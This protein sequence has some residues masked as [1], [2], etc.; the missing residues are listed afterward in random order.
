MRV[1]HVLTSLLLVSTIAAPGLAQSGS[2]SLKITSYPTGA[3]VSI[4]GID[5]GKTTPMSESLTVG[6]HTVLVRVPNSGW[7]PDTRLV[8]IVSGNNDLSVTLLPALTMGPQGAAGPVGPQGVTGPVGPAGET[9]P[10]GSTGPH[11]PTGPQ[12]PAG[13]AGTVDLPALDLRYARVT[14]GNA[15]SGNQNVAG[16]ITLT[17]NLD[18]LTGAFDGGVA[19][20]GGPTKP[21][22]NGVRGETSSGVAAGVA[23][24]NIAANGVG[25]RGNGAIGVEGLGTGAGSRGLRGHGAIGVEGF[26]SIWGITGSTNTAGARGVRG[27]YDGPGLGY[28][29][30]A[31]TAASSGIALQAWSIHGTGNTIG[32]RGMVS[33]P[34]GIGG[35]FDNSAGGIVIQG[36]ANGALRFKVD[37]AGAVYAN[38]YRDLAGN[39]IPTGSGDVTGITVGLGITGGGTSGDVAVGL[40]TGYTDARYALMHHGHNVSQVVGAATLE[41]NMFSGDQIVNGTVRATTSVNGDG[42]VYGRSVGA[43]GFGVIGDTSATIGAAAGVY[44]LARAANGAGSVHGVYGETLGLVGSA[45]RGL[46][47]HQY[48]IGTEGFALGANGTAM[49]AQATASTGETTALLAH[50][51]S[52]TGIVAK[53]HSSGGDFIVGH[54]LSEGDKFRVDGAGNVF[55]NT[56]NI[57][58][59]DFAESVAVTESKDVYGAGDAMI[60]DSGLRRTMTRSASPYSTMVAGIYSTNPGVIASP[61]GIGDPRLAAEIP[62]AVVG[63]VPCKVSAENGPISPG[64]LLVTSSLA[65]HAMKGTDRARMLGAILGKALEPHDRGTGTILVLVTLQ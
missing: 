16:N 60:I 34:N 57:G 51:A 27:S 14:G 33:S 55:A 50:V 44:G 5:T 59:A 22:A 35:V 49:L 48:G 3:A 47:R 18:A 62:L 45:V 64:D 32:V 46:A 12:G 40:D 37:S 36:N 65:G 21:N 28:G 9:G 4:D 17:G 15:F 7:N 42:A 38:S 30:E 19:G 58:G 13:P 43:I 11:G 10:Q 61:Y 26:G 39:P 8:T 56:F 63:I 25:V 20:F 6:E 53:L 23:G 54:R 2:G 24:T 29:V 31:E 1:C 41:S 52:P